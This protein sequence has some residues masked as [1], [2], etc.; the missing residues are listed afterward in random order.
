MVSAVL[1]EIFSNSLLETTPP[2]DSMSNLAVAKS[3]FFSWSHHTLTPGWDMLA[4]WYACGC[5]LLRFNE[6]PALILNPCGQSGHDRK[7]SLQGTS[8][9]GRLLLRD[10]TWAELR[11]GFLAFG[12]TYEPGRAANPTRPGNHLVS[13]DTACRHSMFKVTVHFAPQ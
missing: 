12:A 8:K 2:A 7:P 6:T 11:T 5:A 9:V 3:T 4:R 10:S 13:P 1:L